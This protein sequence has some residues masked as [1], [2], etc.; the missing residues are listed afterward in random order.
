AENVWLPNK[1]DIIEQAKATLE[2]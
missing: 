1:N 2:F